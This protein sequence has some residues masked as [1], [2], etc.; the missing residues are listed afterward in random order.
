VLGLT[1]ALSSAN[2]LAAGAPLL[3]PGARL[4]PQGPPQIV[5]APK[6]SG[7]AQTG[8]QLR[9]THGS[10]SGHATAY[11]YSWQRCAVKCRAIAGAASA[12]YT[13]AEA[14]AGDSLRVAV[15][16]ANT[17]GSSAPAF[18]A[19][20][21]PV[22]GSHGARPAVVA[23]PAI[24]GSA[25]PG[26]QLSASPGAWTQHPLAYEYE[27]ERCDAHGEACAEIALASSSGY[28]VTEADVGSTL[29]V[30]VIALN[31]AGES[32]PAASAASELVSSTSPPVNV[33]APTVAGPPRPGAQLTASP[34][35]WAGAPKSF[36]Y[37]WKRCD[38]RGLRCHRVAA[39]TAPTYV[40]PARDTGRTLRVT[41]TA[42]NTAGRSAPASSAPSGVVGPS[43]E[44]PL[45]LSPPG[46]S[47]VAQAGQPLSASPGAWTGSPTSFSYQ[48]QRC[49]ARG[50]ACAPIAGASGPGYQLGE[51]DVGATLR[52]AVI[53]TGPGGASTPAVSA[54]TPLVTRATGAPPVN[55]APPAISGLAR[56]AG[57]LTASPGTWSGG[58]SAFSYQ[59]ERCSRRGA[60][61]AAIP[62]AGLATYLLGALDVGAT[63]RVSVVAFNAAGASA[64]ARSAASEVIGSPNPASHYEYVFNE[65]PVSVYDIDHS[66]KLVETFTLPGT[67]RGVRGVMVSPATHML[68]VSY[69]GDGGANGSG[70]VLAYDLVS[71]KVVWSV[72]LATG[73]DSGAVS[74]DGKLLYMPDGELSSDGNWNVLSASTGA[75]VGKI[76]T[77]GAGPH[78]TV[79]SA[80][81]K[82]LLLGTRNYNFLSVYDTQT[83]K[84]QPEIGPLVNGVRPLTIN[85]SGT[86]AFTT[87]TGF[88]G[89][90]VERISSPGSVLYTQ[91]FG[92]C[93]GPF[94]TCS[95]GISLSPDNSQAYVIDTV[96]T[97]V[98]VW[99]V[100]GVAA[101][102]APVH[103]ATVPVAGLAGQEAGCAYDCARDGWL[104]HTLDGRYV[105]V[106]DSGSVIETATGA[107]V[108][109]IPNMLNTRKFVEIDWLAGVPLATSGRTGIGYSP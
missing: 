105:F 100:H 39:A 22:A 57:L 51:G 55:L 60:R 72:N 19:P 37:R 81:G 31:A 56:L 90:Q 83:G 84:L 36:A 67:N 78:N 75:V 73:I 27:W 82:T 33:A 65:G 2:A 87:A 64:P 9:A 98:Q 3:T 44:P 45:N 34:G 35:V 94:T 46:I 99:D 74:A 15:I 1:L 86:V 32:A 29:R 89:F 25:R 6:T 5:R 62:G 93:S 68:F 20:T 26:V 17:A 79:L 91:S 58:P 10:W 77:P 63:L 54:P 42:S 95:H 61:C 85:G 16:A 23:A 47:G 38:P 13:P 28:G 24:S 102:L 80:D 49:N 76:A 109:S 59:W 11:A 97:A 40:I 21:G 70:S 50:A 108:A 107:V 4:A 88:D 53:A 48:W 18:S 30:L 96:H 14:D 8:A 104:Q 66:F 52:V 41:V 69:G 71:K 103:L 106:G 7:L 92:A 43:A 12:T 101:G